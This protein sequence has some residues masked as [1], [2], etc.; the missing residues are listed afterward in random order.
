[1]LLAL[2]S[3][4]LS[5]SQFSSPCSPS[6]W[7]CSLCC[8]LYYLSAFPVAYPA[9]PAANPLLHVANPCG[10]AA[11]H[12]GPAAYAARSTIFL[13]I[14][15]PFLMVL[16]P[17]LL[18]LQYFWGFPLKSARIRL[19]YHGKRGRLLK[20]PRRAW[21]SHLCTPLCRS[22]LTHTTSLSRHPQSLSEPCNHSGG[23]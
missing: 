17:M 16:Q 19:N 9:H 11:Y 7:S 5:C 15:Q 22:T 18:V 4:C 6:F 8:S 13:P 12:S 14:L 3:F 21:K 10:P 1:M 23:L 2:L 20:A